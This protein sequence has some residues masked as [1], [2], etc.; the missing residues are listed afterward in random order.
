MNAPQ[1]AEQSIPVQAT[2]SQ[3]A[4]GWLRDLMTVR[5]HYEE[6]FGWPV[7]VQVAERRLAIGLGKVLD[8]VTMPAVLGALVHAQLGIAMLAGPVIGHTDGGRWTFL[9]QPVAPSDAN[10]M[11]SLAEQDVRYAGAG[12]FT[13]IPA[14]EADLCWRWIAEPR[15]HQLLPSPF[16]VVATVRRVCAA[17]PAA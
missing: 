1:L 2:R 8:A 6:R 3:P 10:V 14:G 9:T 13:V 15:P 5:A 7:T 16:A 11:A 4:P 12:S 17:T